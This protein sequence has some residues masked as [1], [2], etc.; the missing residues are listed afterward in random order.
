[1]KRLLCFFL[2]F[3]LYFDIQAQTIDKSNGKLT[4]E[5]YF[6][7][8]YNIE[9][10]TLSST[11]TNAVM[12]DAKNLNGFRYR[13]LNVCYDYKFTDKISSRIKIETDDKSTIVNGNMGVFIK[14]AFIQMDS[15]FH[16]Y[17]LRIGIQPTPMF[18]TSEK[19]WA[20]RFLEKTILDHR[21]IVSSRDMGISIIGKYNHLSYQIYAGNGNGIKPENE[22]FKS[23]YSNITYLFIK[24]FTLSISYAYFFYPRRIDFYDTIN[25]N[26]LIN[27]DKDVASLF[28]GYQKE[29]K[30]SIGIEA[31]YSKWR[32]MYNTGQTFTDIESFGL[33]FFSWVKLSQ[34]VTVCG[35]F[36]VYEPNTH[37]ISLYDK[38]TWSIFSIDYQ[39]TKQI[40]ISPNIAFETYEKSINPTLKP[41]TGITGQLTVYWKLS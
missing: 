12:S 31:F 28:V 21:G 10:D 29:N 6:D 19:M 17:K 20:H 15:I 23:I 27:A 2:T 25:I 24:N 3:S 5:A 34:K 36:D 32:N 13:R 9:R 8:F 37:S 16:N 39:L 11:F 7:Y 38:R 33:T 22:R 4:G 1:M 40:K 18:E 30:F 35:R 41:R 14:D 26:K